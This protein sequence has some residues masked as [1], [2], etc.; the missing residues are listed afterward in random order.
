MTE[1]PFTPDS[2]AE[3]WGCS[4][5]H[6]RS[7]IQKGE[8]PHF[9]VGGKLLRIPAEAVAEI[10][11]CQTEEP[12]TNSNGTEENGPSNGSNTAELDAI[13]RARLTGK[14]PIAQ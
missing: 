9:R 1:R 7:L 14:Q 3:R 5:K 12:D 13:R 6:I 11:A 2:L 8:I 10:E 4:G